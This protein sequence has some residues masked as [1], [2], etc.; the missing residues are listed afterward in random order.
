M[1]AIFFFINA[2]FLF[3]L[4]AL[5]IFNIA[6]TLL[7]HNPN[8]RYKTV[9]DDRNSFMTLKTRLADSEL[10]D[11]GIATNGLIPAQRQRPGTFD[12]HS[13][14]RSETSSRVSP[15]DPT[16]QEAVDKGVPRGGA[17]RTYTSLR[18]LHPMTR[19]AGSTLRRTRTL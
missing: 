2:V 11:I 6:W 18:S 4:I 12:L 16:L 14:Q 5:L 15:L 13:E 1:G 19:S 3:V 8:R 10:R 17:E 9:R 7:S